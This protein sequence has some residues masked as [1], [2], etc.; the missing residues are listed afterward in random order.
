MKV[1]AGYKGLLEGRISAVDRGTLGGILQWG[2]TVLGTQRSEEFT[3]EEG[4]RR[5]VQKLQETEVD[6]LV[7]IGGE[8]SLTGALKLYELG[9]KVVGIPATIDNDVWGTEVALGVD[10]A[11]N[12]ALQTIDRLK[13]TAFSHGRTHVVE[14]MGRNCGY[15][16]LMTAIAGE[17]R[18]YWFRSLS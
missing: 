11:L 2:G 15:L 14:V 10:T 17:P 6:A 13:D 3:T 5:A 7:V 8:G 9:V 16:A 1:E 4:R 12:T 18:R